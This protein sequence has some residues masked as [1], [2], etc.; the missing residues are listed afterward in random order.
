MGQKDSEKVIEKKVCAYAEDQGFLVRKYNSPG[1]IGVPDRIFFGY[2]LCFLIEFKGPNG[3]LSPAQGREIERIRDHG[4][5]VFVV[6]NIFEGQYIIEGAKAYG[7][8]DA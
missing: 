7:K 8:Q 5:K 1:V 4:V 6:N 2:G 3:V